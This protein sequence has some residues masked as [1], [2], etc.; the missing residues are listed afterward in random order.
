M[1]TQRVFAILFGLT[2]IFAIVGGMFSWGEGWILD[3]FQYIDATIPALDLL[4]TGPF[5]IM[6]AWGLQ[7]H[8]P[9][10]YTLGLIT[11]GIYLFGS[12]EVYV[13][14]I[15]GLLPVKWTLVLPPVL[16]IGLAG[17]FIKWEIKQQPTPT[18][19]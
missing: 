1:P 14:M 5:S 2:G 10:G 18:T 12:A 8:K 3:H 11:V 19:A 16:G 4:L 7:Q 6:T 9:W 15:Q 13:M 17:T